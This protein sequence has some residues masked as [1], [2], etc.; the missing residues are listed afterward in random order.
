[1]TIQDKLESLRKEY[2]NATPE[3]KSQ[4][5]RQA[6]FLKDERAQ[7]WFMRRKGKMQSNTT[8]DKLYDEA[9]KVFYPEAGSTTV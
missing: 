3:R 6:A 2:P 9:F 8:D 1:M 4:I 5:E 7:W